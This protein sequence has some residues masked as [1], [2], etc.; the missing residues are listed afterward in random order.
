MVK[1]TAANRQI[2]KDF[3][4]TAMAFRDMKPWEWMD[5][6]DI[7]G[8]Q[9]PA[10]GEI[11]YCCVMGAAKEVFALGI[12]LGEEGFHS[13]LNILFNAD[14]FED[15]MI[16]AGLEQKIIKIEF[17]NNNEITKD[18]KEIYKELGLKFRGKNQWVS[19]RLFLPA[20]MPRTLTDEQALFST[21]VLWQAMEV[22]EQCKENDEFLYEDEE[23]IMVRVPEKMNNTLNWKNRWLEEPEEAE[24]EPKQA[25]DPT[26][27][28]N[29]KEKLP[30]K[31]AAL[32]FSLGYFPGGIL[33]GEGESHPFF[34]RLALWISYG[35][36]MILGFNTFSPKAYDTEFDDFIFKTF[37]NIGFIPSQILTNSHYA[38]ES[39]ESI[40]ESLDIDLIMAPDIKE[41]TDAMEGL[42]SMMGGM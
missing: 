19:P 6:S 8:V 12:Y 34:A 26:I 33:S 5:D 14:G 13:Y 20:Y 31:E 27:I 32:C 35:S 16:S 3:Y 18:E 39:M 36:G 29:L 41:F 15:D 28:A 4:K 11:G 37:Q 24:T 25:I 7:F 22:A 40:A 2:W 38:A 42:K 23:K 9:D 1:I 17:V 30:V 10:S 21:H